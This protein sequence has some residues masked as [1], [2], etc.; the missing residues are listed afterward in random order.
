[1]KIVFFP[2]TCLGKCAFGLFICAA[3]LMAAGAYFP[4]LARNPDLPDII[5]SPVY[6]V[7][8]YSGMAAAIAAAYT[9]FRSILKKG[10]HSVLVFLS[11]P[12]GI[13]FAC[14]IT[15]MAVAFITELFR[16]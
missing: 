4:G 10:E 8:I 16:K 13:L 9:G 3:G 2:K 15:V 7:L 11:I 14:G 1:M 6:A 5:N 12:F